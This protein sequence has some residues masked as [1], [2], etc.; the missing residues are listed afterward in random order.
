MVDFTTLLNVDDLRVVEI[1]SY[2]GVEVRK[3]AWI[4]LG[5]DVV[6]TD[7]DGKAVSV[8]ADDKYD[9]LKK[10]N[11]DDEANNVIKGSFTGDYYDHRGLKEGDIRAKVVEDG[12]D[13]ILGKSGLI[14]VSDI[15]TRIENQSVLYFLH[16]HPEEKNNKVMTK[17][18]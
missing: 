17:K 10:I 4:F 6:L 5:Y 14:S 1:R 8:L 2:C 12:R 16:Y 7:K 18:K 3:H 9:Y 11:L 13:E 15:K